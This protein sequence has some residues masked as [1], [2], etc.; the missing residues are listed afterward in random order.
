MLALGR[1]NPYPKGFKDN[2]KLKK[3]AAF[4]QVADATDYFEPVS[5]TGAGPLNFHAD[6]SWRCFN[7]LD[8]K[9]VCGSLPARLE[10]RAARGS[11]Y[12]GGRI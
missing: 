4:I 7:T 11:W 8:Y 2:Q 10:N 1:I 9:H 5:T 6:I 12:A 3:Q